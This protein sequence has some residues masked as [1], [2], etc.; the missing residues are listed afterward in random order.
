MSEKTFGWLIERAVSWER[1][2]QGLY[3]SLAAAFP[4]YPAVRD[5]WL[6]MSAD[7][8]RHAVTLQG[9]RD[10]LS[11]ERLARPISGADAAFAESVDELL[12]DCAGRTLVT[13]DDA[14]ELANELEGS[15]INTVF[16]LVMMDSLKDASKRT[17]IKVQ[18]D[19]HTERLATFA[20]T[21]G[22]AIRKDIALSAAE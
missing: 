10:A 16:R 17:L 8:I 11:E 14:Y 21:Y 13:L 12:A 22:P 9:I 6:Q 20:Q 1:T 15:E 2:A 19:V 3:E 5:F 18:F 7:E 4:S